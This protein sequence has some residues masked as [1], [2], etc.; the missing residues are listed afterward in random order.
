MRF[1]CECRIPKCSDS[2]EWV[3]ENTNNNKKKW[4]LDAH[5]HFNL[6]RKLFPSEPMNHMDNG[7]AASNKVNTK[8]LTIK[9]V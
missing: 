5:S 1:K 7:H 9:R 3:K 6:R 8:S 2:K 4:N